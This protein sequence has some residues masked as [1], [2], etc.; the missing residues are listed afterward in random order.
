[1]RGVGKIVLRHTP[2][3]PAPLGIVPVTCE[4]DSEKNRE[5]QR[6]PLT[7]ALSTL[8]DNVNGKRWRYGAALPPLTAARTLS[9]AKVTRMS[10]EEAQTPSG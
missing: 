2:T 5:R 6:F 7:P 1:M 3:I 10:D 4:P 8:I 9:L